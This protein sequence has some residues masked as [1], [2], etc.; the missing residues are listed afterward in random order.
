MGQET[1]KEI[2]YNCSPNIKSTGFTKLMKLVI[3]TGE[4]PENN[5][6]IKK[7]LMNDKKTINATNDKK[8]TALMI[9]ARNSC[10]TSN[11]ETVKILLNAG[12][13]VNMQ[14]SQEWTA[15]MMAIRN[16]DNDSNMETV[17]LLLNTGANVNLTNNNCS[18]AIIMAS[19]LE[20]MEIIKLLIDAGANIYKK[21]I[22]GRNVINS[23]ND[24]KYI[25]EIFEAF[26]AYENRQYLKKI[27]YQRI[28]KNIPQQFVANKFKYG[29]MGFWSLKYLHEIK[30]NNH[31]VQ[32]IYQ[33]IIFENKFMI[34]FFAANNPHVLLNGMQNYVK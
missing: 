21:N 13:D 28:L 11:I 3:T 33:L 5:L 16:I 10:T 18:T 4:H 22:Y 6:A 31:T 14:D 2:E 24:P 20:N 12:A 17:K 8:W 7:I 9:A 29:S 32:S 27:N 23:I 25:S 15:L 34:D 30:N 1:S 26:I 19:K